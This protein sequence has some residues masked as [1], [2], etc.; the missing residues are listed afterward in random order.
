MLSTCSRCK[1]LYHPRPA[2]NFKSQIGD[3]RLN[4][5]GHEQ[6]GEAALL[7]PAKL[8]EAVQV[9]L[10][11]AGPGL[12]GSKIDAIALLPVPGLQ[13]HCPALCHQLSLQ[14]QINTCDCSQIACRSSI[15]KTESAEKLAGQHTQGHNHLQRGAGSNTY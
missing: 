6:Q 8:P 4:H 10:S 3:P 7:L 9:A 13:H 15:T 5:S 14:Q 2:C 11:A 1:V 12:N